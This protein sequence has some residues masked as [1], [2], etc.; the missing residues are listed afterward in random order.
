MEVGID[1]PWQGMATQA[2]TPSF[3]SFLERA[4]QQ[5][6]DEGTHVYSNLTKAVDYVQRSVQR[7]SPTLVPPT[8]DQI[9]RLIR[10]RGKYSGSFPMKPELK[11]SLRLKITILPRPLL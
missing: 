2:L 6:E 4:Q 7:L 5:Q 10:N 11:G 3:V 9:Y 1:I 8:Y